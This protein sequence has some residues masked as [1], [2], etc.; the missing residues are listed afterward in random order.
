MSDSSVLGGS[1]KFFVARAGL[2][3]QALVSLILA[4]IYMIRS[5]KLGVRSVKTM[6]SWDSIPG[7]SA[8]PSALL[9]CMRS[10]GRACY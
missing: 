6:T 1:G 3:L 9:D 2:A 8:S 10:V 4:P 5:D 7:V